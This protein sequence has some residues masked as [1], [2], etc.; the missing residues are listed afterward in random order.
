MDSATGA[1]VDEIDLGPAAQITS[2]TFDEARGRLLALSNNAATLFVLQPQPLA[3]VNTIP[4]TSGPVT[5]GSRGVI[6][7]DD[8]S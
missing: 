2:S 1:V 5:I 3:V 8:G 7:V 4:V 6:Q